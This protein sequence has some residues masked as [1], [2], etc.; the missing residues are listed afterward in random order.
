MFM[1]FCLV[2]IFLFF[3]GGFLV[4]LVLCLSFYSY[5]F[6]GCCMSFEG[7]EWGLDFIPFLSPSEEIGN[8][9]EQEKK[10]LCAVEIC[11]ILSVFHPFLACSCFCTATDSAG[12]MGLGSSKYFHPF[13][14]QKVMRFLLF[15]FVDE[16]LKWCEINGKYNKLPWIIFL[17]R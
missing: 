10:S 16:S 17:I 14:Q 13:R 9:K 3:L 4:H 8:K 11:T 5:S 15:I 7:S 2:S 12:T 6:F 1:I